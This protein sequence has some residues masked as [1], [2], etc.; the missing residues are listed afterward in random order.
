MS[1]PLPAAVEAWLRSRAP[2]PIVAV[3]LGGMSGAEVFRVRTAAAS[4]I[5]KL[6]AKPAEVDF[7]QRI[8]PVLG[9][10][11][12]PSPRL[13]G[14]GLADGAP[15]LVLEDIAQPLPSGGGDVDPALLAHLRRLHELPLS[16]LP[17]PDDPFAPAWTAAM[18]AAALP[19]FP[20]D[21]AGEMARTLDELRHEGRPLF[22][23][24][25]WISGDPNPSNWGVQADGTLV[26][27]D[28]ERFGR[29]TPALD[30]AI[31]VPGLGGPAAYRSLAERY[32]AGDDPGG[33]PAAA[34][35]VRLAREIAL[36]KAWSV[37]EF[38]SSHREQGTAATQSVVD[39]LAPML[40]GWFHNLAHVGRAG[41]VPA[42]APG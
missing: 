25:C 30:L 41:A 32:L 37:V 10:H 3:R 13:E 15:W 16:A 39:R 26:L 23:P 21:R 12:I 1:G 14:S 33:C 40:P 35:V 18:N 20:A 36:A 31:A 4:L 17:A 6:R 38:L 27:F 7:Y 5:V 9:R 34:A 42:P 24:R 29:G 19:T 11:G 28:W 8:A 22:R 2:E